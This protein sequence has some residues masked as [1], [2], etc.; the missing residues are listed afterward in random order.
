M[1]T[2]MLNERY[3]TTNHS[4]FGGLK[5]VWSEA[6][7]AVGRPHVSFCGIALCQAFGGA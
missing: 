4:Y 6:L 5:H 1:E 3:L 7:V 2:N